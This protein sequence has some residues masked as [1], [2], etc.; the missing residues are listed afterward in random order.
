MANTHITPTKVL[1]EV[2]RELLNNMPFT[3]NVQRFTQEDFVSGDSKAGDT[4]KVR[5]PQQ[6]QAVK[7]AALQVQP[8]TDRTV[9]VALT[10]QVQV[11]MEWSSRHATLEIEDY[12]KRYIMPAV[13]AIANQIDSDG[14]GRMYKKVPKSVGAPGT[15]PGSTGTLPAA[16]NIVYLTAVTKLAEVGVPSELIAMLSPEMHAYLAS[17]NVTLFNPASQVGDFFKKGY[18]GREALGISEWFSTQNIP[19]HTVGTL[20]STPLVNDTVADGASSVICDGAGGSVT[21]YLKE[22]DVVQFSGVYEVNT[23]SRTTTA[24]LKDFVVTADVTATSGDFTIP[25]SPSF[26]ASGPF[27]NCSNVPANNAVVTIFGHASSYAAKVSPQGLVYHKDAFVAAFADLVLPDAP[28]A[29]R[30][31]NKELGISIRMVKDY[32]IATDTEPT[33]LDALYGWAAVRPEMACRV[34]AGPG[35]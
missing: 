25:V 29:E 9:N 1:K 7:G 30:V 28:V 35:A 11:G 2:G 26:I 4:V 34:C 20:G 16:A 33:R 22:G 15:T 19:V 17:A 31:S 24:R 12:K 13:H 8:L 21:N 32:D 18:F 14:L 6:F 27:Q 23:L 10:D 3:S 5:L